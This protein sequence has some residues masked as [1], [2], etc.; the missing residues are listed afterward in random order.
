MK[1]KFQY[2]NIVGVL[3]VHINLTTYMPIAY[4]LI[5]CIY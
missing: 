2:P 5:P 3:V 4:L 1:P